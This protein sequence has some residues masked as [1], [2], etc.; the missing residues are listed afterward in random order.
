MGVLC[1]LAAKEDIGKWEE[2][3]DGEKDFAAFGGIQGFFRASLRIGWGCMIL[4]RR[5]NSPGINDLWRA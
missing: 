4:T 2:T 5:F 3:R 1:D